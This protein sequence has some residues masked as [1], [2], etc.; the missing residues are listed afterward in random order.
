MANSFNDTAYIKKIQSS[1]HKLPINSMAVLE[2][3]LYNS[4]IS[5]IL[6]CG[7]YSGC[8]SLYDLNEYC[9]VTRI[10][11]HARIITAIDCNHKTGEILSGSEDSYVNVWKISSNENEVSLSFSLSIHDMCIVGTNFIDK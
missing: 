4:N 1:T 3:K 9:L 6:A 2:R 10:N 5:N 11:S 8:I 7:D